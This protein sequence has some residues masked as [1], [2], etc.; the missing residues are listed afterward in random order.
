[1]QK[2]EFFGKRTGILMN[3][4]NKIKS[5]ICLSIFLLAKSFCSDKSILEDDLKYLFIVLV[6]SNSTKHLPHW[7]NFPR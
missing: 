3:D 1:M 6:W 5:L 2:N 7:Q 4:E